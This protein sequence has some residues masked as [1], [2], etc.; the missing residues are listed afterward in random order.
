MKRIFSMLL[1][2]VLLL[3][4]FMVPVAQNVN[5]ADKTYDKVV[6][7]GNAEAL[8]WSSDNHPL[9]YDANAGAWKSTAIPLQGGKEVEYKF[10]MNDQW[11]AG[12]N[13]TFTPPQSGD[14]VFVFHPDQERTVDVKLDFSKFTGKLTLN[15]ALPANTPDWA[16]PTVG[17]SLN[18]FNYSVTPLTKTADG[19]WSVTLAG[20][21]GEEIEYLYSL[22]DAKLTEKTAVKRKAV[23][24]KSGKV[25]QDTVSSWNEIPVAKD[26]KNNNSYTPVIPT[27]NDDVT[28]NVTV[29]HYGSVD[30]GAIYYSADGSFP[31]GGRGTAVIGKVVKLEKS[32]ETTANG[33]T[34]TVFKG[35]IPKQP[36]GTAVKYI[37]DVWSAAGV[38]SQYAD[39]NSQTPE[40]ATPFGYY[41]DQFKSPQ[42]AKDAVIYQVFVDRFNNG[43]SSN[44]DPTTVN[45]PYDEKLKGWMGGDLQGVINK[46]DYIKGL[47]VNTIWISPVFE[48]PYSHG[49]HPADFKQIDK[50][51]GDKET[52]KKLVDQAH[53]KGM[54]IV[55]DFVA[56]HT[57]SQHPFFEDAKAKGE[58]SPYYNWYTFTE[59]PNKY[60][61]FSGISELPELNN[62]NP[63]VRNYIINDVVPYWLK[64]LDF[65]GFRLDYAKGPSYSYWVDFRHKVK[66]LKPNAYIFGEIWDSREKI[67]SYAGELDGALDFGMNDAL[68]NTFAKDQ[69]MVDLSKTVKENIATYPAEYVVSSFL[70]SHDKPRFIYEAGGDVKKMELA[71]ATQFTLPGPPIIYY[72]DE[73]GLSMSKDPNSVQDWKDRY[74]REMMP[75]E[76]EAQNAELLNH[77]KDLIKLRN[78]VSAFRTGSFHSLLANQNLFAYERADKN[79]QYLV[80][81]NKGS[82]AEEIDV[83]QLYNQLEIKNVS[84]KNQLESEELKNDSNGNLKFT[85][86]GKSFKIYKVE[87]SLQYSD[88]PLDRNKLYKEVLLRGSTPLSWDSSN[89]KLT[90]NFAEK[91]WESEP[92]ALTKDAKVEFKFV[93]DGQWLDGENLTFTPENSGK[94][95]F[96]FHALDER[97]VDVRVAQQKVTTK[98]KIHYQ[99]KAGD[100]KDWNLWVWGD[101]KEGKVYPFTGQDKFGKVA[102][103]ELDGD[104]NRVG[105]IV[106]TDAW[107][108][109]GGD[110][111]IDQIWYGTDEV[112]I[113]NGDDK[114][115]TSPP[116]G[117]Y[118][119]IPKY[120]DLE[121]SF[122]YYRYD[123]NYDDW[124]IWVWTDKSEGQALSLSNETSYGKQGTLKLSNLN[125][126]TKVGFIVRKKDWSA[127]DTDGDRFITKFTADGKAEVWL[128]QGQA[129]I[130]DNPAKVDRNPRIVMAA[131]DELNQIT[132]ETNFPF[133]LSDAENG[134]IKLTGAEI[135]KV[136]PIGE[137]TNGLTNK[138]KLTT[139]EDL[140]LTKVYRVSK[141]GFGEATVQMGKVI[142]SKSFEDQFYYSGADLGNNYSKEKTNFRLWA[143]TASAAKIVTYEKWNSETGTEIPMTRSEKGTWTAE[144][145]G[146]QKGLLYTY[147]VKIGDAWNEA[148]DPY[149]KA[150]SVNGDK[151]AVM[152]AAATNPQ[153]WNSKKPAFKNPVDAIIYETHI[154][155]LTI[156]VDSGVSDQYKGKFLGV[157]EAGTKGPNGVNTGLSH[158]KDL[159]I[160]HVQILPMYDYNT[161]DETKLDQPQFNWGYDPK[162]YNAPDGSYSTDPYT[163]TVR[164]NE[165]KTMVQ[166]LHDNNLRV[167]MDVVYNHMYNAGESNFQKLV[168]GY[169]FRYNEDGTLANGTGVGNDTAS[170]HKMMRKFIVDSVT[171]W[172]K[173]Y[174]IDGFRFDLMGIHDIETMKQVRSALN[175]IDPSIIVLGEGWDLNT[176]LDP[177]LKANQKNATKMEGIAHFNDDIRDGLKGSV[178][179]EL[180][181]G[182]VNGKTGMENRIKKGVVGGIEY[183]DTIKT[184]ADEPSK[185]ITYV[186]AHDNL[187]LWD[188]LK[189]TNPN[190]SDDVLKQM[191][192][193]ASSIVL[194]SQGTSFIHAGQEF[195]RTKGGNENSYNAPDSVNQ[196]DWTR[197]SQF[198]AEVEYFKGLVEVR[199]AHPAFR[200]T[201]ATDIKN[202]LKFIDTKANSVAFYLDGNANGDSAEKIAVAYNANRNP[203]EITLPEMGS[204]KLIV[205]GVKA[206]TEA[207][208][209]ING[210][211]ITIPALSTYVL[212]LGE[213][214][215]GGANPGDNNGGQPG[216][217]PGTNN[218]GENNGS[219]PGTGNGNTNPD[220]PDKTPPV[221]SNHGLPSTATTIYNYLLAGGILLLVGASILLFRKRKTYS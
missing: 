16:V 148:V 68:V 126:A 108:K 181:K 64:D 212:T 60:K 119:D 159:G 192:K 41:V 196:L 98:V 65:D 105:F 112:W 149:A 91:V 120:D 221:D 28:V 88:T 11:M 14:Y 20:N 39:S 45:L 164:I 80:V 141:E 133:A 115:Y 155:D 171:Y 173:E 44:D 125:G 110:R 165:M 140:D 167:I 211:K 70:D 4:T 79:G 163:P 82:K 214:E 24:T 187:T 168:P 72:G 54:K 27:S 104:F 166:A 43:D 83:N 2:F 156:S 59:W 182:F 95:V 89:D 55:Y 198:A 218:P 109:D 18:G 135:A 121:V 3:S 86:N 46:I 49:Y 34:T 160:T 37:T 1:A 206:G 152:D 29:K 22:G 102:D 35:V 170:E 132:F 15:V 145:S 176:P 199:K 122:N 97:K 85:S 50:R 63:E 193:L 220:Q 183:S 53:A 93:M 84:L 94:Y 203:V 87:G 194:T 8:D 129:R 61:S 9:T 134:G 144:L 147:K 204:W 40:E 13:L 42:W 180:D 177:E 77:Y 200:L 99:P 56:N 151:G 17:S 7:R 33:L 114:V 131:I 67:N 113:K 172:A 143:P 215:N 210:D 162:N 58:G 146:D 217:D 127:K 36:N 219:Q 213:K 130:F 71:V 186:E 74:Y 75:W 179:D 96:V 38:G 103:V 153:N 189:K 117:E 202:H 136:E 52:L 178:F 21:E 69:S 57:S 207:I 142:G 116:D 123:L 90:Y 128:A 31:S 51:F 216:T 66:E 190:D 111:I 118:R 158:L 32:A 23:F 48:G 157:A 209:V 139:K 205:N 138:V 188:K 10:V 25:Y 174:H 5:A 197:R 208:E 78:D 100:T 161:V 169:Y 6:L 185:T 175:K 106:R 150:V 47:G 137:L 12:D 107:E 191:H 184:F 154:R 201:T 81:V 101:G 73:V 195:L 62:D 30:A 19:T 26:V 76:P 124:D 92:I